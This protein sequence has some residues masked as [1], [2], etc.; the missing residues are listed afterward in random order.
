MISDEGQRQAANTM[1]NAAELNWRAANLI[2]D[3]VQQLIPLI[4]DGYGNVLSRIAENLKQHEKTILN[5]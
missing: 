1:H 4:G 3:A 2:H 5:E